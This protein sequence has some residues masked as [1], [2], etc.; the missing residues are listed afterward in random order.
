MR[1]QKNKPVFVDL[2]CG[3]GGEHTGVL[4]AYRKLGYDPI[5]IAVNHW[6]IAIET[7]K[8]NHPDVREIESR[9]ESLDPMSVVPGGVVDTL[10]ASPSCTHHSNAAGGRPKSDQM[11]SQPFSVLDWL[12]QLYVKRLYVENVPAM[13]SWG[14]LGVNKRPLKSMRGVT[15][16]AWIGAIR[17]LG[18]RVDWRVLNCANYGVPQKRK[19][20]IVQAVRGNAKIIWPLPTHS[21]EDGLFGLKPWN[22]ADTCIDWSIPKKPIHERK[23][24]LCE[25]TIRRIAVG[26]EKHWKLNPEPF[27]VYLRGTSLDKLDGSSRPISDPLGTI[28]TSGGHACLVEPFIYTS[29]HRSSIRTNSVKEPLTTIVTKAE[30]CLIEPMYLP[31][32]S[33]GVMRPVSSPLSTVAT[34]GAIRLL[35]LGIDG[36]SF[37]MLEAHELAAGQGFPDGYKFAGTKT[38]AVRQIGNA[39]PPG[40]ADA[41][42]TSGLEGA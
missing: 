21:E 34:A 15:F 20:L 32:H 13:L 38:Q 39:V 4:S 24:P 10:W 22:G 28:S 17:S 1:N 19:R 40:V 29:G 7:I 18:Y 30:H 3:A 14:P 2:F 42:I 27:M 9:V 5:H 35:E 37:R 6:K 25:N 26:I 23:K 12:S 8:K 41:L 33:C 16:N 11:R 31:Q 36:L